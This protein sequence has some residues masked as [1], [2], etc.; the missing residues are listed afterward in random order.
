MRVT[1]S[2]RRTASAALLSATLL[3]AVVSI[4]PAA[5]AAGG[6]QRSIP[7]G[8]SASA[9]TS[10]DSTSKAGRSTIHHRT[11]AAAARYLGTDLAKHAKKS[12]LTADQLRAILSEDPTIQVD[13]QRHL[14]AA[15]SLGGTGA[16]VTTGSPDKLIWPVG[17]TLY[18]HSNPSSPRKIFLDFNGNTTTGT[19]WNTQTG[20]PTITT[21]IWTRDGDTS[22]FNTN[23]A[24]A[25]QAAFA[26]VA[27]DYAPFNVDITTQDPGYEGLRRSSST[28]TAYGVRVVVGTNNWLAVN[29]S[30]YAQIGS[31]GWNSDT[32]AFCF[33]TPTTPTKQ[34]AEC[35]SHEAGHTVGLY[36]DGTTSG[37]DYYGGHA[38]WAPIMGNPY[39]RPV[40]QWSKGQYPGANNGQDDLYV[41]G[42]YLGWLADD[43]VGTTA[44][45]ATLPA[46]TTRS[47]RISYGSGEYD[48][49]KFSLTGTRTVNIQSWEWFQSVDPNLNMRIELTNAAGTT[50]VT[51]SPTGTTRTNF[52]VTLGAGTYYVFLSGVG[53]GS[54]T[55]GYT[56][57]DSLGMY[58]LLLQFV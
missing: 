55:T 30:G 18:L 34:I 15:D 20:R 52:N 49:F 9:G 5:D 26:S 42:G 35:V 41:I 38:N 37:Q 12:D 43:Y 40:T 45:T 32:P 21:P 22:T 6:D 11:G 58:N 47:G 28:D 10:A 8:G 44:T 19:V 31:F 4:A 17:D 51:A 33:T 13:D 7:T 48:A 36:H 24:A 23:E 29:N 50:L 3:T 14:A 27:E 1:T 56:N 54:T 57:Y 53:E 2:R 16:T 39:G 46:G 25:I